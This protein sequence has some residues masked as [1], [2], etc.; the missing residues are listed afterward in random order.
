MKN[1]I[2][3]KE[4]NLKHIIQVVLIKYVQS[5]VLKNKIPMLPETSF[6]EEKSIWTSALF[7]Q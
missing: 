7:I 6:A 2:L 3:P 1:Y 5:H 4:K